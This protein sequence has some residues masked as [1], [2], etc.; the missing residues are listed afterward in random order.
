MGGDARF[1]LFCGLRLPGDTLDAVV[2]WQSLALPSKRIVARSNLHVTLAFL[3][4]RP[5]GDVPAVRD[6]LREAAAASGPIE[7]AA[8]RYRQTRSVGM[9]VLAD[10]SG[11]AAGLAESLHD[12]LEAAGVYRREARRW[13]PHLTVVRFRERPELHPA[14]SG[15]A[16][17]SPSD[18]ALYNSVLRSTGAQYDV[19]DTAQLG[20]K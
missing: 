9:L 5:A 18:V 14:P 8:E 13:L 4:L 12:L 17:F 20:G 1:R 19:L 2:A 6:A 3:G 7:L 10:P 11:A 16:P 15:L